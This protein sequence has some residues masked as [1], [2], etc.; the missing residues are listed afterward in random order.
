MA[1]KIGILSMQRICNYGSF[2]QAYC[3]KKIPIIQKYL[4]LTSHHPRPLWRQIVRIKP[5]QCEPVA[6]LVRII[7]LHGKSQL[8]SI[9]ADKP[10][11]I[12]IVIPIRIVHNPSFRIHHICPDIP[13]T[14]LLNFIKLI[15]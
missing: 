6:R 5:R 14:S 1:I 7:R 9:G 12:L 3:L 10:H 2:L 13:A 15:L 4:F 11:H 8:T